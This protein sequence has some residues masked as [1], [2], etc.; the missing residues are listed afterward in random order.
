MP[1]TRGILSAGSLVLC[2]AGAIAWVRS[3]QASDQWVLQG[4]QMRTN[5]QLCRSKV[6]VGWNDESFHPRFPW[7]YRHDAWP[8]FEPPDAVH[9]RGGGLFDGR[10]AGFTFH[11][12]NAAGCWK[13]HP[14]RPNPSPD[15]SCDGVIAAVRFDSSH[16]ACSAILWNKPCPPNRFKPQRR[17]PQ[18]RHRSRWR[19]RS[20]ALCR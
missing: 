18:S 3:Y 15:A 20:F 12:R 5:V 9:M 6:Q 14:R 10:F 11:V 2:L 1:R 8:P 4:P 16:C 17:W 13:S 19:G 7:A